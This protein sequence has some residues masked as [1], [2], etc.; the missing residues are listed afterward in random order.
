MDVSTHR[1]GL[2]S[3]R[4]IPRPF[5]VVAA[6][7]LALAVAGCTSP[8]GPS[9]LT[10]QAI[11][12]VPSTFTVSAGPDHAAPG[13]S[14]I[15]CYYGNSNIWVR[16]SQVAFGWLDWSPLAGRARQV[17]YADDRIPPPGYWGESSSVLEPGCGKMT[18]GAVVEPG[19]T[20]T[21]PPT[22]I[23]EITNV[24][25]VDPCEEWCFTPT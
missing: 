8:P 13:G 19:E 3:L 24:P 18:V 11:V 15:V 7:V 6:V 14:V 17:W 16:T 25:P 20:Y 4:R 9:W 23:V 1:G 2:H 10:P 22:M 12:G 21:G 5:A